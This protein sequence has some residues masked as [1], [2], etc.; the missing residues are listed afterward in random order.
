MRTKFCLATAALAAML[1]AAPARADVILLTGNVPQTDE[2][3]LLNTGVTGNPIFG[4]TNQTASLV[5]FDSN[6]PLTAPAN[7]QARIEAAD[8]AFT[9]LMISLV[10]N[11]FTSLI[12]NLDASINGT[13]DFTAVDTG[14][15]VF[16]FDNVAVG[17]AGSN[18]FTFLAING[19]RIASVSLVADIPLTFV[20]AAQFRIGGARGDDIVVP[21]PLTLSLMGLGLLGMAGA[22]RR[23]RS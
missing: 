7:G 11:S 21:E 10:G 8:G 15:D 19:Q 13:V 22:A 16:N 20:D 12:F 9:Q 2:N 18:F 4:V 14:G 5:R 1:V 3:V 17:G 6:E 23:R